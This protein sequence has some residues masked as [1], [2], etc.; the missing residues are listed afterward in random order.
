M[1]PLSDSSP[2]LLEGFLSF[3]AEEL[4]VYICDHPSAF[5]VEKEKVHEMYR[6]LRES[7]LLISIYLLCKTGFRFLHFLVKK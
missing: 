6:V 7:V 1:P 4:G 3:G 2:S 5:G